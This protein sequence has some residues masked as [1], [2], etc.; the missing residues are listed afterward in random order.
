MDKIVIKGA[1]EHNLKNVD[2]V[3]PRDQFVVFTGVSGSGK[4][5]LAFD[6]IYAEGQRRYVESLSAYARQFLEQMQKPDVDQIEGLSPA[7]SI[8]QKAPSRNPRSTVGT[9]TEIYDYLRLLYANIGVPHCPKCHRPIVRQ[10]AE[11][12]V[13]QIMKMPA[14]DKFEILAPAIRGRK[15]EYKELFSDIQKDGF[16]RVRI[17]GK[18]YELPDVP[19]IDKKKK[20]NIDIVVDRLTMK[21]D[22]RRRLTESAE[23]A[24][25]FGGGLLMVGRGEGKAR[26]EDLYSEKFTCPSCNISL[27]EITPRIFSF[28]TPYG[29]CPECEGLGNKLEFDP[30]LVIPDKN[31]T[32]AEGAIAPWGESASYYLVK[33][34]AVGEAYGFDLNTPVKKLSKPQI[35]AILYGSDKPL[36]FKHTMSKGYWEYE[37]EFEGVINNLRRRYIETKSENM[38]Y[39]LYR[40]MSTIPCK[41]CG[42]ARLKPE[43]LAVTIAGKSIS[44]VTALPVKGLLDFINGLKLSEKEQ[45]ISRQVIKEIKARV[46]FLINVGLDYI[47]L[48]RES[49]TLSGGEA[50]RTRLATQVGSGLVGVLYILDEPSIG[51]HQRDNGRL[52]QSLRNLRD[53]GNTV[54]VVEHDEETMEAADHLVDIG[55]GA[56]LHGGQIVAQGTLKEIIA[57][58][59][60]ITGRFLSGKEKIEVP[61]A[62]RAGNGKLIEIKGAKHHNLKDIDVSIPLGTLT[63]VTG[64]SGSGKSSLIID[65]LY[66]ALAKKF[67]RSIEKEGNYREMKGLEHIDKVIDIDQTPIGRTPRSNPATYTGVFNHIRDLF[68]LTPEAKMRGYQPGR[69]SFNVKGGRCEACHGDGLV[70]IEMHFLPDVY[71]PCDVCKG[72]RY[73]RET[74]EVHYKGKNI[75]DVLESTVEEARQLFENIPQIER[76]LATLNDVG[77]DYI[78]LG[79]FATTLSGGEAQRIKLATELSLRSTGRTL[80]LLDEPTTGLHFHD[81]KK[82]MF[83]LNRLVESGNSV[84]VIEHNLD[85][86]KMADHLIDLGPEGGDEGGYIVAEG[87]PEQVAKNPKSYTGKYLKKVL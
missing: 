87:T 23:T 65:I 59:R 26:K 50:Q 45:T 61:A 76:K 62:R 74:L 63:C 86:I 71:V 24:L 60:S 34:E 51:L 48:D 6:T 44:E 2:L 38:R 18:M 67:Y 7:I 14:G 58:P 56:G 47:T 55:P 3:I 5:S 4:S 69:F 85:V 37:G 78:K 75:S 12:I 80:Y 43:S 25:R 27:D 66:K 31:L 9:V 77:L 42:G 17:D 36:K 72:K 54:I 57:N 35:D 19:A 16:L 70:K 8:D 41:T 15:G 32:L 53:L 11:Q 10:S 79:Q 81:I 64:V 68:T 20:H 33:L 1:R 28:N 46:N 83:V 52:I 84:I 73:N 30:D 49:S 39:F 40:F 21:D 22:I 13:D 29:A 82:L